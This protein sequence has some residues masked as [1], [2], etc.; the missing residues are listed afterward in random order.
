MSVYIMMAIFLMEFEFGRG[1]SRGPGSRSPLYTAEN[2][3][4]SRK[5]MFFSTRSYSLLKKAPEK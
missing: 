1:I 3:S 2:N 5:Y 4:H